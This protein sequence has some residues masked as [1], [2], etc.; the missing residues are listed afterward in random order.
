MGNSGRGRI[1]EEGKGG[2]IWLRYFLYMYKYGTLKI[3]EVIL[4][5]GV[6]EEGE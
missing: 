2:W 6:G 1:Y 4:R 3:V 5:S